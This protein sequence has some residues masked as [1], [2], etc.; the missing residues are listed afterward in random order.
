MQAPIVASRSSVPASLTGKGISQAMER[1]S[2]NFT[3]GITS[4]EQASS[5]Q[6][7]AP[8]APYEETV[9]QDISAGDIA[10]DEISEVFSLLPAGAVK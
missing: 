5:L 7:P 4:T 8:I 10:E 2:P 3:R 9:L 1:L 6:S